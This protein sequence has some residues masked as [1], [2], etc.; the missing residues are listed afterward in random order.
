MPLVFLSA[1]VIRRRLGCRALWPALRVYC[2]AMVK[3]FVASDIPPFSQ[4]HSR[5][6]FLADGDNRR[7]QTPKS[8]CHGPRRPPRRSPAHTR[9]LDP[10]WGKGGYK[11][12]MQK[13][14]F[15][16]PA[17]PSRRYLAL[18]AS[19]VTPKVLASI[20]PSPKNT[21]RIPSV[22]IVALRA[23]AGHAGLSRKIHDLASRSSPSRKVGHGSDFR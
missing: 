14:I 12:F 7:S 19:A 18:A 1:N 4:P 22:R 15:R 13:E 23:R 10:S 16:A 17:R 2:L 3:Y 6:V 21:P 5:D 9:R 11:H 8:S 20:V